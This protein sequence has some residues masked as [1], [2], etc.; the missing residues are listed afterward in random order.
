MKFQGANG[1]YL[2]YSNDIQIIDDEMAVIR[3]SFVEKIES[4]RQD[5]NIFYNN[6]FRTSH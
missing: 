3:Y 5:E 1:A 2:A 4:L 6:P